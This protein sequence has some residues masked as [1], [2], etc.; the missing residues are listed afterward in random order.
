MPSIPATNP[1]AIFPH[2]IDMLLFSKRAGNAFTDDPR[3]LRKTLGLSRSAP[4]RDETFV[5][6][7][8]TGMALRAALTEADRGGTISGEE[9][10]DRLRDRI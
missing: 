4:E 8:Q 2:L 1:S 6:D 10:L 5:L 3:R 7:S 9:L